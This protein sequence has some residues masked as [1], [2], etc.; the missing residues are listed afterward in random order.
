LSPARATLDVDRRFAEEGDDV[1]GAV[2]LGGATGELGSVADQV[3]DLCDSSLTGL[4]AR[5]KILPA[6]RAA[7]S[8]SRLWVTWE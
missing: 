6:T 8:A 2:G 7:A 1:F 4:S 5:Q 3:V